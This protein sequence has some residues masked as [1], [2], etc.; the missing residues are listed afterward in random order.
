M[1]LTVAER[2]GSVI[3]DRRNHRAFG[4]LA[5][6]SGWVRTVRGHENIGNYI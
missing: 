6:S 2:R 3:A 1:S 4:H 5:E